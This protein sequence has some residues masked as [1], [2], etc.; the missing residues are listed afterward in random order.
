MTG[1]N[2][3]VGHGAS[4]KGQAASLKESLTQS[5]RPVASFSTPLDPEKL[6]RQRGDLLSFFLMFP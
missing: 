6:S 5:E 2:S 1:R 4:A 3:F